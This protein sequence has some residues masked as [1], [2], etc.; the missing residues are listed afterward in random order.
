MRVVMSPTT[1]SDSENELLSSG[2]F[3]RIERDET[4]PLVEGT[5]MGRKELSQNTES[6]PQSNQAFDYELFLRRMRHPACR[7][8]V[9]RAKEFIQSLKR[10]CEQGIN[11][12]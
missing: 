4:Q 1:A 3:E 12:T 8:I 7:L 5:T 11:W 6:R 9:T 10:Q 2:G